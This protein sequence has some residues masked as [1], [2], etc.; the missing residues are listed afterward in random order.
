MSDL[1]IPA[2]SS[3]PADADFRLDAPGEIMNWMRELLRSQARVQLST[4]EGEAIHTVLRAL[5]T[6]HGMLTMEAPRAGDTLAPVLASDELVAT[7]YLDRIKLQFDVSG[8]VAIHGDGAEVLRAPMPLRLYRF[9]R[10]QAYRVASAGQLYPALKLAQA[11]LPR[12]RV[13]NVSAGGVALQWPANVVP[14]P[15]VGEEIA[16]TLELEREVSFTT[17]LRV[18]HMADG[19]AGAPHQAGCAFVSLAPT[20]A[21]ALQVFIDQ[22]QKR[23]RLMRRDA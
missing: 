17:L 21:R 7:A 23:E 14:V 5:D 11:D 22:A 2:P 12:I 15:R 18:Q 13:V 4:P 8:L 19:D 20:A 6:P 1:T 9:Q 10:R 16:A 3:D